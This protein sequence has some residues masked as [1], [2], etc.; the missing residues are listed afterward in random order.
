MKNEVKEATMQRIN[1]M[2]LQVPK[3]WKDEIY[4]NQ[5]AKI[6]VSH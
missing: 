6:D 3:V 5:L 1:S 4:Q 2:G